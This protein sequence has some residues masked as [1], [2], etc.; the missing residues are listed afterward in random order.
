ME[1]RGGWKGG[2]L[3]TPDGLPVAPAAPQRSAAE[4]RELLR[5]AM[6]EKG[7]R[8]RLNDLLR[9]RVRTEMEGWEHAEA[10]AGVIATPRVQSTE[11]RRP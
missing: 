4:Y 2:A 5:S 11:A 10:P 6:D 8:M 3:H 7:V 9:R 1:G